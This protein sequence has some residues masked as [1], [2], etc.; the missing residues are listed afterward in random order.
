MTD[1]ISIAAKRSAPRNQW[2]DVWDQ[3]KTH[4]GALVGLAVFFSILAL[5]IIG[6]SDLDTGYRA[7]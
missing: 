2:W 3:F 7:L 1:A 5:I 6:P 4:K